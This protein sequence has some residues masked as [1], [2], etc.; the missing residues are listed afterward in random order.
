MAIEI[1]TDRG[2][3]GRRL[4]SVRSES[5]AGSP[6]RDLRRVSGAESDA[7]DAHV[8]ADM[9]RT[10]SHQLRPVTGESRGRSDQVV[11]RAHKNA[12]ATPSGCGHALREYFP[13]ALEAFDD[14][15]GSRC[16]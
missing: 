6:F 5:L 14:L 7:A 4:P 11:S 2:P 8:L 10:D 3:G 9:V 1:E 12:P 13:A 16:P 15:D